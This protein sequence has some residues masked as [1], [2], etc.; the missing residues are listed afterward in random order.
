MNEFPRTT[1]LHCVACVGATQNPIAVCLS[2][3]AVVV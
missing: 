2:V 3:S 1:L